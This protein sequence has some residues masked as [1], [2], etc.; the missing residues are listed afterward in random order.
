MKPAFDYDHEGAL[1][2]DLPYYYYD[3]VLKS[4]RNHLVR[5]ISESYPRGRGRG[6]GGGRRGRGRG[7]FF[8]VSS[9][10]SKVLAIVIVS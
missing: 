8:H 10:H 1:L 5:G 2:V 3:V 4:P 6:R 9:I 7:M